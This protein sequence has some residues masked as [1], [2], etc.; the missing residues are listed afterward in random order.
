MDRQL[1][2]YTINYGSHG[3]CVLAF[4]EEEGERKVRQAYGQ[5]YPELS[6]EVAKW[7]ITVWR[8]SDNGCLINS[9]DP[10]VVEV[11]P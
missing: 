7:E 2:R 11:Y 3:G 4:G 10:D 1:Y 8:D 6:K 5:V 9:Q